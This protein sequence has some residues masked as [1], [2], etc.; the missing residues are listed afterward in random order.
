MS[1]CDLQGLQAQSDED[2]K[3]LQTQL[4]SHKRRAAEQD[5]ALQAS[6]CQWL[7]AVYA[8]PPA[9]AQQITYLVCSRDCPLL[10]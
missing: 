7:C 6:C 5:G 8:W 9:L 10:H 3:R 2:R 4:D 1:P